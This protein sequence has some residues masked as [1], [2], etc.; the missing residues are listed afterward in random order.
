[1]KTFL[2]IVGAVAFLIVTAFF[3]CSCD[4]G[5]DVPGNNNPPVYCTD[6]SDDPNC[7]D[8]DATE[9][10]PGDDTWS[11]EDTDPEDDVYVEPTPECVPMYPDGT[12]VQCGTAHFP[13]QVLMDMADCTL[14]CWKS[15][16]EPPPAFVG[17]QQD[18][19]FSPKE[20]GKPWCV[21]LEGQ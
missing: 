2:R 12:W 7:V 21:P 19:A 5:Q 10:P 6:K 8:P 13:C 15:L 18:I 14:S 1:M 20:S 4:S 3:S 9:S 16:G 17:L 11:G